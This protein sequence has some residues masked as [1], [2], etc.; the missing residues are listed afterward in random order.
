[1]DAGE[2]VPDER[3][4]RRDPRARRAPRTRATASCSTAS[5]ARRRR[6]RRSTRRSSELGRTLTAVLLIDVPDEEVVAPPLRP[7]RVRRRP[8]HVY[9]VEFDP[10]KHEGVCDRTARG[11]SSAT[12]T[13]PR[14]SASA[15]RSTTTQTEPLDRLLRGAR[16]AAPLRRHAHAR[17]RCTTTSA[18]RSR[19]C[20]SKTSCR[21]AARDHQEDPR[22]D[23]EDGRRRAPSSSRTLRAASRARSAPGVT[24]ARARRGRRAV[25][26]L[27]GRGAGLQGLPR[28][29]GLDLRLAELDGRARHPGPYKLAARRHHLRRRRRRP[30]RLGRRRRRA[31][32]RSARSR[33]SPR[34][35]LEVTEA[36]AVR[37]RR[38]VPRRQPPRR[39]LARGAGSASRP[40]AS[41]SSARSSAT[42]SAATCTRTRRSR[43]SASRA[44][45]RCSRRAWCS[46]SSRWS[47]PGATRS[48]WATTAGRSTPRTAR[49]PPTSSSRSPI[50]ADGPR[51]PHALARAGAAP[52]RPAG[53]A[54]PVGQARAFAIVTVAR[55]VAPAC[56]RVRDW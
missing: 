9:H 30:R 17:P 31:R 34:K 35:L 5:R 32:S 55:A 56:A 25:H 15:S 51:D 23:R 33:R 44:A 52:R 4:H 24:T 40:R 21:G 28:L 50:T 45:A 1:M 39:R 19:R 8:G 6:P 37:R 11:S 49:W 54:A 27:A 29:P 13:S 18:R 42:A 3:D 46:P 2:L 22:G 16:P 36:L 26:P 7:P 47:P 43:T 10:P 38:A 20:A 48:G 53:C 14:R 41:R 12:T